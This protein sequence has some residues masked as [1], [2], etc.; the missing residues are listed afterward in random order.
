MMFNL[1]KIITKIWL[2]LN[3]KHLLFNC[4]FECAMFRI[5][6]QNIKEYKVWWPNHSDLLLCEAGLLA[7]SMIATLFFFIFF[8][9]C[10]SFVMGLAS[11]ME[12]P[13]HAFYLGSYWR[14]YLTRGRKKEGNAATINKVNWSG[15]SRIVAQGGNGSRLF[16]TNEAYMGKTSWR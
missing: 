9:S 12:Y 4:Y 3:P 5:L 1:S 11:I 8:L 2:F 16:Q 7:L 14:E 13:T 15:I 6:E 10:R